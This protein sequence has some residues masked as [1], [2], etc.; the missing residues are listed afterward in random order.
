M[1]FVTGTCTTCDRYRTPPTYVQLYI[2]TDHFAGAES[3]SPAANVM[4]VGGDDL[5]L[6]LHIISPLSSFPSL[7]S[8]P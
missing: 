4:A 6:S 3:L 8:N 2:T 1:E 5:V 7:F